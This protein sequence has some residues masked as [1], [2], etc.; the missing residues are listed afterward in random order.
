MK[1]V[2]FI[3]LQSAHILLAVSSVAI[4]FFNG[5]YLIIFLTAARFITAQLL[6]KF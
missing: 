5:L 6:V 4:V 2:P 3:R 1:L